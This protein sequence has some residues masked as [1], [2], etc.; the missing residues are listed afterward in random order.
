MAL[1]DSHSGSRCHSLAY[2]GPL[3]R[4][5]SLLFSVYSPWSA[6]RALA[7]LSSP[8][9]RWRTLYCSGTCNTILQLLSRHFFNFVVFLQ[10]GVVGEED[11]DNEDEGY[12]H[13]YD[14]DWICSDPALFLLVV[15]PQVGRTLLLVPRS[16][17]PPGTQGV[18]TSFQ[19]DLSVVARTSLEAIKGQNITK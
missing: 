13:D 2:S 10:P 19:V 12:D 3:W 6:H 11:E 7:R 4:T 5:I 9:P 15:F 14:D 18:F 16:I 1:C 8:M 17:L